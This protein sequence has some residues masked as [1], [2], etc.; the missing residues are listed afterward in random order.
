MGWNSWNHFHC[1]IN[2]KIIE[3]A[4]DNVI[5]LGLKDLGYNYINIDDCW[6]SMS[7]ASN[8]HIVP[9]PTKF[10][11]MTAVGEYIHEKGLL[12]GI[13]S[14]AGTKTCGGFPGGLGHETDDAEDYA[15]WGVDYLK[16]DN[17]Y[18]LGVAAT[19]RYGDMAAALKKATNATTGGTGRE[20]FYSICNWGDEQVAEWG[21]TMANS[22]RTTQD[23]E[24]YS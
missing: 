19:K 9:D 21:N 14:S 16:Y 1:N 3:S 23:I 7:R 8:D 6:Q 17:C 4:A 18:N 12:F 15:K 24:I 20:I 13:Y 11:N 2:S 5:S 22:W 10:P